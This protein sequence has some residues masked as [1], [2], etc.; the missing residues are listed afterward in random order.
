MRLLFAAFSVPGIEL[1]L[2]GHAA[3]GKP[4]ACLS[5]GL[6]FGIPI[7]GLLRLLDRGSRISA[8]IASLAAGLTG[9][10]AIHLKCALNNQ[11]TRN[12]WTLSCSFGFY[13]R[14][15]LVGRDWCPAPT[16]KTDYNAE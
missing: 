15:R 4:M 9:N 3:E 7:Y 14:H 13:C 6:L 5:V 1:G 12:A 2:K 11:E 10:M 8:L 16:Q